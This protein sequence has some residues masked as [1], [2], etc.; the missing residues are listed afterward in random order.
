MFKEEQEKRL[1]KTCLS[2]KSLHAK[3][4]QVCGSKE[5]PLLEIEIAKKDPVDAAKKA[6]NAY[7]KQ[8]L[9]NLSEWCKNRIETQS[10]DSSTIL[11]LI[12]KA[13]KIEKRHLKVR[14][15]AYNQIKEIHKINKKH[16]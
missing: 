7:L 9:K 13:E 1:C 2:I 6:G 4:C 5:P 3:D 12:K 8:T 10:S 15:I 11:A 16:E 14:Q